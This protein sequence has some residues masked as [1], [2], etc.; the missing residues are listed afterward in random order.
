MIHDHWQ[1]LLATTAD[2]GQLAPWPAGREARLCYLPDFASVRF[3]GVDVRRFLQGYLTRDVDDLAP[4]EAG[5][6]ALCNIKGR[7]VVCGWAAVLADDAVRL[8]LHGSLTDTLARFLKPY[9]AFSKTRLVDERSDV[10]V[11]GGS[12][13]PEDSGALRLNGGLALLLCDDV[14]RAQA[15]WQ[16]S[17]H[18]SAQS[19][20]AALTRTGMPV[21]TQAVSERFLPQMLNLDQLG[22]VDFDKGCYLGQEVVARAQH[23]GAVKRTLRVLDWHGAQPPRPGLELADDT[24]RLVG[25][26]VFAAADG[27]GRG[28]ATAVVNK[29]AAPPWHAESPDGDLRLV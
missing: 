5:P 24:G 22:A 7:V 10:L 13:L 27:V 19:W 14:T 26:V 4:G 15:L 1:Q 11:F 6:V 17:A 20:L 16:Q 18:G 29:D 28:V 3:S 8:V 9:L 25:T 12:D 2:S 21:V 23:R